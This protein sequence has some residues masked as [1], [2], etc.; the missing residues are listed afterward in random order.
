MLVRGAAV[1]VGYIFLTGLG[2]WAV[3]LYMP[4]LQLHL[5]SHTA[6]CAVCHASAANLQ[7]APRNGGGT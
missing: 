6:Q 5:C 7:V 4:C 2:Q 3:A 1:H